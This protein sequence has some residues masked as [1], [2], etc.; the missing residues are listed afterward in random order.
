M[1][2]LIL[3]AMV[4]QI[5]DEAMIGNKFRLVYKKADNRSVV[6]YNPYLLLKFNCYINV[7]VCLTVQCVKY[8]SKYF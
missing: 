2:K 6:P 3:I 5:V 4:I 1:N 7:D 8:L